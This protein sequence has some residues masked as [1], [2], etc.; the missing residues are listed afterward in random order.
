MTYKTLQDRYSRNNKYNFPK[1]I[2]QKYIIY[3][4]LYIYRKK[5]I[6]F[7]MQNLHLP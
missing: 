1:I 6:T 5:L 2:H 7:V 4:D 3:V